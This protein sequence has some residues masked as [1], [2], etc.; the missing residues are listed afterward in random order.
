MI[1]GNQQIQRDLFTKTD[2]L[3]SITFRILMVI[4]VQFDFEIKQLN[5]IN[6]FVNV[7]FDK[8]VFMKHSFGFENETDRTV[9]KLKKVFYKL[10]KSFLF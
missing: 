1:C 5:A 2:L 6:A 7:Y 9:L 3:T 4:I 8:V 10:Q